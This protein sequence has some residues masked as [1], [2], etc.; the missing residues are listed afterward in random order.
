M[1]IGSS[2]DIDGS[3]LR[4]LW[5]NSSNILFNYQTSLSEICKTNI[6]DFFNKRYFLFDCTLV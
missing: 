2:A 5:M 4:K 1:C 3:F 6:Y